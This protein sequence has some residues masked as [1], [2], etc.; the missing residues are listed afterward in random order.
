VTDTTSELRVERLLLRAQ[1]LDERAGRRLARLIAENL[2]GDLQVGTGSAAQADLSVEVA[3][4]S[5]EAIDETAWRVARA[6]RQA[7]VGSGREL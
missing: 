4:R 2:A 7:L 1:G 6:I 3:A 5:G